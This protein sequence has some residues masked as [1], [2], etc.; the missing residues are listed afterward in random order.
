MD[1]NLKEQ[2]DWWAP[3]WRGLVLDPEARH[4]KRMKSALWLF[5][6]L[7]LNADRRTG[8]LLRKI[9]TVTSDTGIKERTIRAWLNILRGRGYI[10][11]RSLGHCLSVQIRK[12]KSLSTWQDHGTQGDITLPS[13]M[14][15]SCRSE[16]E[17][18][19]QNSSQLSP[20][21]K[22]GLE[23]I[24]ITIK[25]NINDDI[26]SSFDSSKEF[27]SGVR[28]EQLARD[29]AKALNDPTGLRLYLSYAE[30]YP[31]FF[32]RKILGV[33]RKIP[34]EKIKKSRGALFNHLIQKYGEKASQYLSN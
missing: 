8:H 19:G 13:R 28:K 3:V 11:T 15:E 10:E 29:L 2:K 25:R 27:G 20:K 16:D 7:L 6:Y 22:G 5:L 23:P 32:L 33:V 12:W 4:Y 17:F 30:R 14:A 9:R 18:P 1:S 21:Q 26:D 24:D 34:D 31:E